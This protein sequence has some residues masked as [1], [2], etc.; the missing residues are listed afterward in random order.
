M[1]LGLAILGILMAIPR[2]EMPNP[3]FQPNSTPA[4]K[5]WKLLY[6][7]PEPAT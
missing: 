5:H 4:S 2:L 7:I 3:T 1:Q 6:P